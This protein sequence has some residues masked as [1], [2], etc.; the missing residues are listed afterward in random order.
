MGAEGTKAPPPPRFMTKQV[1]Q[2]GRDKKEKRSRSSTIQF[3]WSFEFVEKK[4][5]LRLTC[6][7]R[8]FQ[9]E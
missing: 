4:L 9:T 5:V 6:T 7:L 1:M 2:Y 3:C 8:P